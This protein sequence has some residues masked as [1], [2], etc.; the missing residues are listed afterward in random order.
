MHIEN[1][2]IPTR[3]YKTFYDMPRPFSNIGKL[4]PMTGPH[5]KTYSGIT[6]V[7]FSSS[8]KN[9]FCHQK[10]KNIYIYIYIYIY[11]IYISTAVSK[12]EKKIFTLSFDKI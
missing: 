2:K 12:R 6:C 7:F 11:Y 5:R 8:G 9:T 10:K 1:I 4:L 3:Q